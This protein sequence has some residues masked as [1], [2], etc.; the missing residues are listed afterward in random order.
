MNKDKFNGATT[1]TDA[2]V[3]ITEGFLEI[4]AKNI[5]DPGAVVLAAL[6]TNIFAVFKFEKDLGKD[7]KRLIRFIKM[8]ISEYEKR[9]EEIK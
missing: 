9:M 6:A 3:K 1:L 7:P 5:Q 4:N 2:I 8:A